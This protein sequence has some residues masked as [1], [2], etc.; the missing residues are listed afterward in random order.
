DYIPLTQAS[1]AQISATP[2]FQVAGTQIYGSAEDMALLRNLATTDV[3]N[4]GD[5]LLIVALLE[6]E[7]IMQLRGL[8]SDRWIGLFKKIKAVLY[9]ILFACALYWWIDGDFLDFWDA[10]LWL[11][12]FIFI[13]L[14]IFQ[15][16]AES[17]AEKISP[18]EVRA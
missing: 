13:E 1:C 4:S 8:L 16:Q 7:V 10:F 11:V 14:N 6:V 17:R 9:T 3:V 2:V 15:W 18:V 12:A 5:W